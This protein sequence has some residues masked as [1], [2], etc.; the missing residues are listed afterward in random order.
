ML[1]VAADNIGART[2][3]LIGNTPFRHRR[4]PKIYIESVLSLY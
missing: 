2:V 3:L 1:T 4:P